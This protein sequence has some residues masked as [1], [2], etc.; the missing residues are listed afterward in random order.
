MKK[1]VTHIPTT[2]VVFGATGDLMTKKI[3]PSLYFLHK[4]KQLPKLF[5]VL[6]FSHRDLSDARFRNHVFSI[7]KKKKMASDRKKCKAFLDMFH[8]QKGSFDAKSTYIELAKHLGNID[9]EWQACANK[10][11]YL[12]VPPKFMTPIIKN[13]KATGLH[14][15]CGGDEGWARVI[16]EKPFGSDAKSATALEKTLSIFKQEQIYRIDHYLGKEMVQGILNFRFSNN[17]LE[18][19]WSNKHIERIDISLLE[20]LGAED[21]GSFY[22]SV[23]AL[24]DVVQNHLLSIVSLL[25]MD[26]P[27]SFD[28]RAIRNAREK[29][30]RDCV[31]PTKKAIQDTTFR[32]QYQGYTKIPGV[33][34]RSKVE[35]YCKIKT[36]INSPRWRG[37]PIYIEAGKRMGPP[38]KR[39]VVTF[40]HPKPCLLCPSGKHQHDQVIFSISPKEGISIYFWSKKPG[41][42]MKLE[43]RTLD[44]ML[45][46]NRA[47]MQYVQEYAKLLMDCISGDQTW[48]VSKGEVQAQWR[49]IDPIRRAWDIGQVQLKR[50]KP[51]SKDIA[52]QASK[53]IEAQRESKSIG[54]I[55]L[56]RMGG[57]IAK[58]LLSH[59]WNVVGYNRS[60]EETKNLVSAGLTASY[61]IEELVSKLPSHKP[62]VIWLMIPAGKAVDDTLFNKKS[63][64][65]NCLKRGDI[66]IDGGN[67]YY[68]NT[69]RRG[70]RLAK[71]GIT[72]LDCGV[73]GGPSGARNGAC[74]MIGGKKRDFLKLEHLF[75]DIAQA[76]GYQ[77]FEGSGAGHFV[78][79]VHNGI[80]YGMMQALGEGFEILKKSKFR[81]DPWKV[82][83][84]YNEGSVIESRFTKWLLD[85]F[86]KYGIDLEPISGKVS[87]SGEGQWTVKTAHE[88]GIRDKVIHEA[89]KFRIYSQKNPSYAGKIV[90]ALR[91][92]FGEHPVLKK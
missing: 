27:G 90:S 7:L 41:L 74:L 49:I 45:Y 36:H 77:F 53:Y 21:R 33:S 16:V 70:K 64:L 61:S 60:E 44:F 32:A 38:K 69:I 46:K 66:I 30:L 37:V 8:F 55:G 34:S 48:F 42:N 9:G 76:N 75:C 92:E 17:L 14:T 12:A 67:S 13:L 4:N 24:R 1:G 78:K 26:N 63:G 84:V 65:V 87:H 39:V 47:G 81:P 57:G 50:Y 68:K 20:S 83:D 73:S 28:P 59:K 52:K 85:A 3:V 71:H 72:F 25:A 54:I 35:T 89:F 40:K 31:L 11:Y 88:M 2:I 6:G 23:G 19:N 51:D 29:V 56:G 15:P 22:E 86:D 82:A 10:L 79:M 43:K 91:G 58:H 18:H 5:R 62:R 80:E